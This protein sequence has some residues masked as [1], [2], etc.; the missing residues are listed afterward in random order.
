MCL[1]F[2]AHLR[3]VNK[4]FSFSAFLSFHSCDETEISRKIAILY[5]KC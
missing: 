2:T 3:T 1:L 4:E 5:G